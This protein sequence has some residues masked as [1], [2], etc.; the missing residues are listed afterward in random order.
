MRIALLVVFSAVLTLTAYP[1]LAEDEL[2]KLAGK[3]TVETFQFNG[4]P[5]AEMLGAVRE[6]KGDQYSL[7]PKSGQTYSGSVKIDAAQR[8]QHIDLILADRTLRGI[9]EITGETAA[10]TVLRLAYTLEGDARP[11]DFVSNADSGV[12][13]VVHKRSE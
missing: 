2:T 11:T 13:L 12:V 8:P 4:M 6:F 3:W 5:V 9:Y 1:V 7:T 10:N